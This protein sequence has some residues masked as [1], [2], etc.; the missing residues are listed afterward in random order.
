MG[1]YTRFLL[2]SGALI[3][4]AACGP[5]NN[6]NR[7]FG[8]GN[9]VCNA[10]TNITPLDVEEDAAAP[11]DL[12]RLLTTG[13]LTTL[14][15]RITYEG[16]TNQPGKENSVIVFGAN[17]EADGEEVNSLSFNKLCAD[18]FSADLA[19]N[20]PIE[21]RVPV[22]NKEDELV[23]NVYTFEYGP[24]FNRYMVLSGVSSKSEDFVDP[25]NE[26]EPVISFEDILNT[27]DSKAYIVKVDKEIPDSF[28]DENAENNY[29][30]AY[31]DE[32]R[33]IRYHLVVRWTPD[34]TEEENSED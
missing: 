24:K 33:G 6:F 21:I 3:F 12:N 30:I 5:D 18:N 27:G 16:P 25:F 23:Y 11:T 20:E 31:A 26:D 2:I 19:S 8:E 15:A 7:C 34:Q 10:R 14:R 28:D 13:T 1:I 29:T 17:I 9:C 4:F 32:E 22:S